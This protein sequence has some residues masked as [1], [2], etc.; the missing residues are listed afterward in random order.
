MYLIAAQSS[1]NMYHPSVSHP[2][3]VFSILA[4]FLLIAAMYEMLFGEGT[5][6]KNSANQTEANRDIISPSSSLPTS[7]FDKAQPQFWPDFGRSI[8]GKPTPKSIL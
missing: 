1:A 3:M 7:I 5:D 4:G 8:T 2:V 6:S